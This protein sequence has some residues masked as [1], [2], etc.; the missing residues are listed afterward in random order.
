MSIRAHERRQTGFGLEVEKAV[1]EEDRERKRERKKKGVEMQ[2]TR[3]IRVTTITGTIAAKLKLFLSS[4]FLTLFSLK[5]YFFFL[6][7]S[8]SPASLLSSFFLPQAADP[9]P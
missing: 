1:N 6:S 8:L 4:H 9:P 3:N 7:F 2:V 5:K